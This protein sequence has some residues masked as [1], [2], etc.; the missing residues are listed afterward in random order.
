MDG[1]RLEMTT[2]NARLLAI[3]ALLL[4]CVT[5][6]IPLVILAISVVDSADVFSIWNKTGVQR[7]LFF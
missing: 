1:H 2:R 6:V 3:P 5:A 4:V 7:A